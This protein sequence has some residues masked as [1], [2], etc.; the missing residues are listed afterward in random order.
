MKVISHIILE[1]DNG[2]F[3]AYLRDD[4]PNIPFP[5]HWDL[6]GGH[7]DDGETPEESLIRETKEEI[8]FDLKDFQFW[9]TYEC[10][11]GDVY[12]N[13]KHIY[14]GKINLPLEEIKLQEGERLSFFKREEIKDVKF[15]N[16]L[17][18]IILDYISEKN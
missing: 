14:T 7:V 13:I 17:K 12:P 8:D 9:K 16:I 10:L 15:A 5:H 11:E 3:L 6:I 4:V 18:K 2:E 1:N